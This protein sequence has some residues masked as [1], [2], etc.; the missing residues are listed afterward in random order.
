MSCTARCKTK[1]G[2]T[3]NLNL[4]PMKLPTHI[5]TCATTP[6]NTDLIL[7]KTNSQERMQCCPLPPLELP[8]EVCILICRMPSPQKPNI[9]KLSCFQKPITVPHGPANLRGRMIPK[10]FIDSE[11]DTNGTHLQP[12]NIGSVLQNGNTNP[13]GDTYDDTEDGPCPAV[14]TLLETYEVRKTHGRAQETSLLDLYAVCK[15]W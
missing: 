3:T 2:P 7:Q 14:T 10:K 1:V 11:P 9:Q 15:I 13:L 12:T 4:D 6:P 8:L 5:G